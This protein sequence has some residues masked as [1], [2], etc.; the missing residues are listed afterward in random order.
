M[1][2]QFVAQSL[3]IV[4]PELILSVGAMLLLMIG[5]FQG[6]RSGGFVMSLAVGLL[7]F[8]AGW[9]CFV[10]PNGVAFGGSIIL[11][12]FA[13]FMKVLVLIASAAAL[14]MSNAFA[15]RERFDKFEFPS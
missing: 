12:P 9:L 13:R 3:P 15:K 14:L 10:T 8:A 4:G 2:S 6:E 7:V 1:F 5:T 11:D